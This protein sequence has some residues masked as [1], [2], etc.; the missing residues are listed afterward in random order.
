MPLQDQQQPTVTVLAG[1][2]SVGKSTMSRFIRSAYPQVHFSVSAT[3]RPPRPG[4]VEGEDYLFIDP[5]RFD[6]LVEA[7]A[8]LEWATVHQK[9]RYGTLRSTVEEALAEGRSVLLEID[10]QG[11]RQVRQTMPEAQF[12]FLA[13]PTWDDLVSRLIGRGTESEDEQQRRLETAKMELAAE[14]EFDVTVTNDDVERAAA[15][16]VKLMGFDPAA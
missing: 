11:A 2:T 15:E 14:S 8:F 1:P 16:L 9:H 6:E 4:E 3:T 7:G 12:V 10:L 13:P 5:V